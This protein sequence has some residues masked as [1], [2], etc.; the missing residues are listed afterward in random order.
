MIYIKNFPKSGNLCPIDEYCDVTGLTQHEARL[1][2]QCIEIRGILSWD[3]YKVIRIAEL[4]SE[5]KGITETL[6]SV[7]YAEWQEI[8]NTK[9]AL[10]EQLKALQDENS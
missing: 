7:S 5:I 8:D 6:K 9:A 1:S 3:T 2:H 10:I 4:K